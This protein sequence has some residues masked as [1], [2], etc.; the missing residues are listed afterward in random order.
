ML[1][2]RSVVKNTA[3][4][5]PAVQFAIGRGYSH[6]T[7]ADYTV[8]LGTHSPAP[9]NRSSRYLPLPSSY[10]RTEHR[11]VRDG[12][13]GRLR[14]SRT[15]VTAPRRSRSTELFWSALVR[16]QGHSLWLRWTEVL[17]MMNAELPI[18]QR[19]ESSVASFAS[20]R[21]AGMIKDTNAS[22]VLPI[23]PF[24]PNVRDLYLQDVVSINSPTRGECS[25]FLA[26]DTSFAREMLPKYGFGQK[27]VQCAIF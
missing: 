25:L 15:A 11:R 26:N 22:L 10:E 3:V 6:P 13:G 7:S 12:V 8:N 4:S 19:R 20:L 18:E 2:L 9:A 23:A 1:G 27:I 16:R 5:A 17:A 21:N 14:V 24:A